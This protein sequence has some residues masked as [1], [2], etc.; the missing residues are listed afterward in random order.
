MGRLR[1]NAVRG[2]RRGRGSADGRALA[3]HHMRRRAAVV[4]GHIEVC[5]V[6]RSTLQPVQ[7]GTLGQ[8]AQGR[9][10]ARDKTEKTSISTSLAM[11]FR[12]HVSF[13]RSLVRSFVCGVLTPWYYLLSPRPGGLEPR[14][15]HLSCDSVCRARIRCVCASLWPGAFWAQAGAS[16]LLTTIAPSSMSH[17]ACRQPATWQ[18]GGHVAAHGAAPALQGRLC[19]HDACSAAHGWAGGDTT[20]RH[21]NVECCKSNGVCPPRH[22]TGGHGGRAEDWRTMAVW[23]QRSASASGVQCQRSCALT[24]A[25]LLDARCPLEDEASP[26]DHESRPP[27]PPCSGCASSSSATRWWPPAAARCSGVRRS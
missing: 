26:S 3:C 27:A 22:G 18:Q 4:I 16:S 13:A 5:T 21:S 15:S 23:P 8:P 9:R 7:V 10:L 25:A 19:M 20:A 14:T 24:L 17:V 1:R 6:L 2:C 11:S 12:V